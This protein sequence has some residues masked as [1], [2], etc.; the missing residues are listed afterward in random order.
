MKEKLNGP[1]LTAGIICWLFFI[2]GLSSQ[3]ACAEYKR[4]D[5]GDLV[6]MAILAIGFLAPAGFVAMFVSIIFKR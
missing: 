2:I 5:S 4:C 1:G 3:M 6:M